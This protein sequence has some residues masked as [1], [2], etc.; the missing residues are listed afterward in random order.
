MVAPCD[1]TLTPGVCCDDWAS[2]PADAQARAIRLA[3]RLMWAATGR[4]FGPCEVT[5]QPCNPGQIPPLYRVYPEPF[6]RGS[7]AGGWDYYP[8]LQNGQWFNPGMGGCGC[9]TTGCE[10]PLQGP[11]RTEAILEVRVA[12]VLIDPTAYLVFNASKLARVD[13][14]CWP[15]CVNYGNQ[16]PPDFEVTY[17]RGLPVPAAVL[18]AASALAC[19]FGK[20]C[21][22]KP[23]RLPQRLRRLSRQGVE[24]EV[25][26]IDRA[27]PRFLTGIEDID[28]VIQAENPFAIQA[29]PRV[30]SPD[31]RV[32]RRVT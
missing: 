28:M 23:C 3:T 8:Y 29:R 2:I 16:D 14:A 26:D 17:L 24:V 15:G 7:S 4:R 5:V 25:A 12:G 11:T 31:R 22:G 30:Y 21:V 10:I 1:W 19:E 32:P 6:G 27:S 20:A 13:G 9:C 18:D